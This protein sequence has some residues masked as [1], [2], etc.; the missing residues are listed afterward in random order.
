MGLIAGLGNPAKI[1]L[2]QECMLFVGDSYRL[3]TTPA[4]ALQGAVSSERKGHKAA[5]R[6][7]CQ[8]WRPV[9][10]PSHQLQTGIGH[11]WI[12]ALLRRAGT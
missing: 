3:V 12:R 6:W 5:R 4:D 7:K 11:P 8:S 1:L 9:A 2:S 10:E